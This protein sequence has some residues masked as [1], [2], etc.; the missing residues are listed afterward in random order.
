MPV[1]LLVRNPLKLQRTCLCQ[2][3]VRVEGHIVEQLPQNTIAEA[4]V[5]QVRLQSLQFIFEKQQKQQGHRVFSAR[6]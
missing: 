1:C 5:V 4:I 6:V 2:L 3:G